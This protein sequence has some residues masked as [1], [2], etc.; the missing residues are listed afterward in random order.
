MVARDARSMLALAWLTTATALV[1]P[2]RQLRQPVAM[3]ATEVVQFTRD[4]RV[5]DHGGLRAVADPARG[6]EAWAPV[7]VGR[8]TTEPAVARALG[9]LDAELEARYGAR[10][11]V[12]DGDPERDL[13]RVCEAAGASV[14]HVCADDPCSTP[15]RASTARA[16]EAAGLDVAEWT[17]PL[18]APAGRVDNFDDYRSTL[19]DALEAHDAPASMPAS[20]DIGFATPPPEARGSVVVSAVVEASL[21]CC[22]L[23]SAGARSTPTWARAARPSRTRGSPES[24]R[25][26]R[27]RSTRRRS[28]GSSAAALRTASRSASPERAFSEPLALGCLS[29]REVHGAAARAGALSLATTKGKGWRTAFFRSETALLDVVEWKEFHRLV[30]T[31]LEGDRGEGATWFRWEGHLC[32]YLTLRDDAA[33]GTRRRRARAAARPADQWRRLERAPGERRGRAREGPRRRHPRLRALGEARVS[34]T[35]HL[36]EQ[37]IADFLA[38]VA[39]GPGDRVVVAGNSIGGGLCSGV[40]ANSDKVAGLVLC[41]SAGVILDDAKPGELDVK[42]ETLRGDL[43]PYGGPPQAALDAVGEAVIAGLWPK[44]PEL[45]VKY[46][47]NNPANADD[48]LVAAISRDALDPGAA[49]VIGSGAKLPPQRSL[50]ED[51]AAYRGPILVPQGAYDGVTGPDLAQKR[52]RDLET[53]RPGIDV[54]LLDAGHCPTTRRRT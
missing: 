37:Y 9:E 7:Y 44:I 23:R 5:N 38:M 36:W 50:N 48:A 18:R 19:G 31:T 13:A 39:P 12:V 14:V 15:S 17:A 35:Q 34:Y 28:R 6:V 2:R 11:A 46:Y 52:A 27:P 21:A 26:R 33:D 22:G 16:L 49:N 29:M 43:E 10:L 41:N 40:A 53:I 51:F 32:R 54:T 24:R 8:D 1:A 3:A 47:D 4:L 25:R 45:L 42:A 30:A 20:V